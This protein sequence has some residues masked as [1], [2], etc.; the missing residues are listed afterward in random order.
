MYDISPA[1]LDRQ[2]NALGSFGTEFVSGDA[3]ELTASFSSFTGLLLCNGVMADL[4]SVLVGPDDPLTN[5][6]TFDTDIRTFSAKYFGSKRGF[7]HIGTLL[8]LR[9]IAASLKPGS[10]A[11]LLEYSATSHNQPSWFETHFECGIDF[12]QIEA[13]ALRLGFATR[14]VN[15]EEILGLDPGAEFLSIDVFTRQKAIAVEIPG[16]VK[17]WDSERELDVLAYTRESLREALGTG[18]M[19]FGRNAVESLMENLES[20]FYSL[21]DPRFDTKNPTTWGY[22]CLLLEKSNHPDWG[23]VGEAMATEILAEYH[24]IPPELARARIRQH[25]GER[26]LQLGS[27]ADL[28][29]EAVICG[30]LWDSLKKYGPVTGVHLLREALTA[31]VALPLPRHQKDKLLAGVARVLGRLER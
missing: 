27:P 20:A 26:D 4:R 25:I 12:D 1:L 19:G 23:L 15:I 7:L 9:E 18:G 5:Y 31:S 14:Q 3:L 24:G 22:K 11:A 6:G 10:T 16:V 2:R 21:H 13:Y 28:L 29:I 8:F 17:L 30:F